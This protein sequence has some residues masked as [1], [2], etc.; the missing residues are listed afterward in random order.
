[1]RAGEGARAAAAAAI[2]ALGAAPRELPVAVLVKAWEP[3]LLEL[4]DFLAALRDALGDGRVVAL[5]PVARDARG[6]PVAPDAGVR[7]TWRR[8][9]EQSGDPWLLLHAPEAA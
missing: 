2:A 9:V 3:P 8:A 6:E 7:A 5:V 4:Q 1:V